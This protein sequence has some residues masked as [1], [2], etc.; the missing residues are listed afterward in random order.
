MIENECHIVVIVFLYS[1]ENPRL[2]RV[3][4]NDTNLL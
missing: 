2:E 4:F 1:D 3:I